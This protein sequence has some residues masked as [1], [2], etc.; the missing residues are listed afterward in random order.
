[1]TGDLSVAERYEAI[2][3]RIAAACARGG[4]ARESVTLVGASKTHP[5]ETLREAWDAGLR[6]FGENR[7]Q[8]AAAKIPE[9][10]ADLEWHLLGPL[11]TNKA[12]QAVA[13]FRTVHSIDRPKVAEVLEV[14]ARRADRRLT[15]FLEIN[16]GGEETKHGFEPEPF[17][18]LAATLRP[19]ADLEFVRVVGLMAIPPPT[20]D[21]PTARGWFHQLRTL[22]DRLAERPE[23]RAFPGFLSMG[24]SD[25]FEI[26]IEEGATH[27]R[28][29]TALFG[30]RPAV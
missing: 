12:R 28:V 19:L 3:R 21:I 16:V 6:I 17:E 22:R 24:M 10:P 27:V 8:E 1:M 23:W 2:E 26:A 15:A 20:D 29:G 7:V 18:A 14:E 13:L 5:P 30:R 11:Q 4:R 9:L 25:D